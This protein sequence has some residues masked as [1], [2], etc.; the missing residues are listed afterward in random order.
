MRVFI[1]IEIDKVIK[2][3]LAALQKDMIGKVDIKKG[4]AK[5]VDP[6]D[7]HLTLKFLGEIKDQQLVE[8]CKITEQVA[9]S[10][11]CFDIE[12]GGV[13]SFGGQSAR[14]IWVGA[15]QDN[16]NLLKL[17][18]DLETQLAFAGWP[19]EN[20]KFEGHLT[21]CR[22]KNFN[23][24]IKLA[25]LAKEYKNYSL[26]VVQVDSVCIFQ[27]ELTPQGPVYTLLGKYNLQ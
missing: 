6:E 4:D 13:G 20:R 27:S 24:G 17:Q 26:D 2:N 25:Q 14:V 9:A 12:I 8:V 5:W 11:E 21:L 10:H 19:E 18:D 15:G 22:I 7:M 1:A 23:A 3:D 16:E